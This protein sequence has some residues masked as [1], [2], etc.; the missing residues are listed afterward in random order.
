MLSFTDKAMRRFKSMLKQ[1]PDG[2]HGVRIYAEAGCCGP[3]LAMGIAERAEKGD[4]VLEN[5]GV[6]VFLEKK[7]KKIL[8]GATID[9]SAKDGIIVSGVIRPSCCG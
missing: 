4:V 8:S 7:A 1:S 5:D 3:T 9:Y 2:A 6:K